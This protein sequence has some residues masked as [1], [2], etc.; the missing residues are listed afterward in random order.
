MEAVMN[1]LD[2][3]VSSVN[4][5][6]WD[7]LLMY[8]LV[9]T[10]I[11]FTFRLRFI[12]VRKFGA[13]MKALFGNFSLNGGSNGAGLSSFQAL[14]T[15]IAAQ[16]GTGNIAGAATAIA[17]GGPGAIFWMWVSAFFGMATI[18]S[19]AVLAQHTK[20]VVDGVVTGGP[21]YYIKAVFKGKFGK[22]LAGF[23]SVAI[24]LALGFMGNMVQ[25]NSIGDS[26]H[27]AFGVNPLIVGICVAVVAAV[28]FIGGVKRIAWVTEKIVPVMALFYIVGCVVILCMCGSDVGVAFKQ[29]FVMAF[30]PQ[31]MAG[32]AL[33]ITVQKAMRF[34]VARGLFSNEA[35]M[36]STPHAHATADVKHPGDQG[37][38]AMVGVFIDTFVI[39]TLTA[40]VI[41]STGALASG[42]TAAALAQVAFDSAFGSF[43]K[44]FI[45]ICML[46]FAFT[47]IIGWYYFGE[48]N[49]RHLL[50]NKAVKIYAF[51]VVI[52][53]LVGSVLKVDLVWNMSDMF[54]GLMVI[55]NLIAILAS[56]KIVA[57]LSK[58]YEKQM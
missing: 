31:A 53:V 57:R 6:L 24:I 16:V 11:Y 19:E 47:T 52:C 12:Q 10:G 41:L 58:E 4:T 23:F 35:G 13:G 2:S 15:A 32:G 46:F 20:K 39:L 48:V 3:V 26:F 8:L 43:G 51:L 17:A 25:S 9:A 33:G 30:N 7:N 36:G 34:G 44:V 40:L 55:P 49:V 28:I 27:N 38:I 54:N 21:V 14:T 42:E 22:F 5:L 18:Y 56:V 45:A 1:F 50:G 37:I 29:I